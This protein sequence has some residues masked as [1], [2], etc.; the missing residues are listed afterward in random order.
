MHIIKVCT[1][2]KVSLIPKGHSIM[3]NIHVTI[4]PAGSLTKTH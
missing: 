3:L 2:N 1:N 4:Q